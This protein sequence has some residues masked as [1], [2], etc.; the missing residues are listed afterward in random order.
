MQKERH[1]VL[2]ID[3]QE[4][5]FRVI[6]AMLRPVGYD[7]RQACSGPEGLRLARLK[8]PDVILLDVMM[9][10][11]DGFEVVRRL[12]EDPGTRAIPVVMVTALRDLEDRVRALEAGA[13][14]FLTK[15]VEISELRARIK[16]LCQV[17]AYHDHL[18]TYRK[19]LEGEVARKTE[20]LRKSRQRLSLA[21]QGA[22]LAWWD[23]NLVNGEIEASPERARIAGYESDEIASG[24][25]GWKGLMH[26]GDREQAASALERHLSGN[27]RTD[28]PSA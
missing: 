20:A 27:F 25:D 9:P 18:Q 13:D 16:S 7:V 17:K 28:K 23:W 24:R 11:M 8:G 19:E 2:V 22:D 14:D 5:S 26:P 3:D 21:L 10:Q 12:K 1:S 15:P 4:Q 6:E